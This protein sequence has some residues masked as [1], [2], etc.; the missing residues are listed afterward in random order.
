M[1]GAASGP[2]AATPAAAPAALFRMR[3]T[4]K[5]RVR[6]VRP[7]AVCRPPCG[8]DLGGRGWPRWSFPTSSAG[9]SRTSPDDTAL[10][11]DTPQLVPVGTAH[12]A[13]VGLANAG[14][15]RTRWPRVPRGR[16]SSVM[17]TVNGIVPAFRSVL[18]AGV[19]R[20]GPST[21]PCPNVPIFMSPSA[22][23]AV[24][25]T[26]S[27]SPRYAGTVKSTLL[28]F[29]TFTPLPLR[30]GRSLRTTRSA[31]ALS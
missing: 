25:A 22:R 27:G 9:L 15:H 23:P 14:S 4:L 12:D 28:P 19:L 21:G 8:T 26:A 30:P 18:I 7:T 11:G 24:S 2:T 31:R 6:A 29:R 20:P 17:R 13:D 5:T 10:E 1:H 3:T 16:R